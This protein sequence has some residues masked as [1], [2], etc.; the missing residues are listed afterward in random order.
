MKKT[1]FVFILFGL[2]TSEVRSQSVNYDPG[3]IPASVSKNASVVVR[4]ENIEFVVTDIDR[5]KIHVH[6]IFTILNEQGAK[7]LLFHEQTDK[8]ES[9]DDVEI[10]LLNNDGAVVENYK[11]NDLN[12]VSFGEGLID[13]AK[14]YYKQLHATRFP[15]TVEVTFSIKYKGI[16]NYPSYQILVAGRGVEQSV[17]TA[18]IIKKL[19]LR[20]KEENIHLAACCFRR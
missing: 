13:D 6:R 19:D 2:F 20:F 4:S 9:L 11:Q 16:L 3:N 7:A 17:Y 12:I 5:A 8:F 10:K 14:D 18:K 1:I 15:V